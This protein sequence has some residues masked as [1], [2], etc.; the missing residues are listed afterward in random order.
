M[1]LEFQVGWYLVSF[2]LC[3]CVSCDGVVF[4][5][6]LV[7]FME[8]LVF[9]RWK[10]FADG[11]EFSYEFSYFGSFLQLFLWGRIA[12]EGERISHHCT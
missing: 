9:F 1:I 7:L 12:G 8:G 2:L 3:F 4:A 10:D 11:S 5:C 6:I